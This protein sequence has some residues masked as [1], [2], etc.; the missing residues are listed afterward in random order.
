M[1]FHEAVRGLFAPRLVE[2]TRGFSGC[3]CPT[4]I[5]P[6]PKE[7]PLFRNGI[8]ESRNAPHLSDW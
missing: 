1:A 8:Q 6:T 2:T 3:V 4:Q 7:D 5:L